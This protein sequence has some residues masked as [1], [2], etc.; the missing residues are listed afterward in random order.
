MAK[1]PKGVEEIL[2]KLNSTSIEDTE[3]VADEKL[4]ELKAKAAEKFSKKEIDDFMNMGRKLASKP[5]LSA[6]KEV[7]M[8]KTPNGD[9]PVDTEEAKKICAK[10]DK[11]MPYNYCGYVSIGFKP[12][13]F[14]G[15][16]NISLSIVP[17]DYKTEIDIPS[18]D[19]A[20]DLF[21]QYD[22]LRKTAVAFWHTWMEE[23]PDLLRRI[24]DY[25]P[26]VDFSKL[27]VDPESHYSTLFWDAATSKRVG[28][29]CYYVDAHGR[30]YYKKS[31]AAPVTHANTPSKK[32]GKKK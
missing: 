1:V 26:D 18:T 31:T 4:E 13:E 32:L 22:F 28:I 11:L 14:M 25:R 8:A 15:T 29:F 7:I 17:R 23:N 2:Q 3:D 10:I 5:V 19:Y 30:P 9:D 6:L 20:K 24:A 27:Q 21:E 12:S 16:L